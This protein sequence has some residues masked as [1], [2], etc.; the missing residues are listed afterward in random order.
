MGGT[1]QRPLRMLRSGDAMMARPVS[2][3]L[4]RIDLPDSEESLRIYTR[5]PVHE[6]WP[7]DDG[8]YVDVVDEISG[9]LHTYPATR[10]GLFRSA[11]E[12]LARTEVAAAAAEA[13]APRRAG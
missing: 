2:G 9:A 11:C 5:A 4:A 1:F 6:L 12:A 10:A 3:H 8:E 7:H 13:C